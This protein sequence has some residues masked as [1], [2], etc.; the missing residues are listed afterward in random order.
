MDPTIAGIIGGGAA[1]ATISGI[2]AFFMA[3]HNKN[4]EFLYDYKKYILDKRKHQYILVEQILSGSNYV[5]AGNVAFLGFYAS[6]DQLRDINQIC[7]TALGGSMW[8]SEPLI[9]HIKDL[10]NFLVESVNE[11]HSKNRGTATIEQICM[12][13]G[14]GYLVRCVAC[15]GEIRSQYFTDLLNLDDVEGFRS[16]RKQML[17]AN[18]EKKMG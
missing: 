2:V 1:G 15:I 3:R 18:A 5:H 13:V 11:I 16:E 8:L 10:N 6:L 17:K 4:V 12:Q 9:L 14:T 7:L